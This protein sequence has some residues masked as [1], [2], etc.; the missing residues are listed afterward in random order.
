MFSYGNRTFNIFC[1]IIFYRYDENRH[2]NKSC[3]YNQNKVYVVFSAMGSFF[4]PLVVVVYVYLK[5][6]CVIAERHNKLE[7]LNGQKLKV[8]AIYII[9]SIYSAVEIV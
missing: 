5:I 1:F 7:A 6:S 3:T 4:L 2:N 9:K 8:K